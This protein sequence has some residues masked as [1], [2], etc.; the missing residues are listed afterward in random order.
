LKH[1]LPA[2]VRTFDAPLGAA[3]RA[4]AI[5]RH[6]AIEIASRV[7]AEQKDALSLERATDLPELK[8]L[9]LDLKEDGS[10]LLAFLQ[11]AKARY[12]SLHGPVS[13]VLELDA[14]ARKAL[15]LLR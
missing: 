6:F 7:R 10:H 13:D 8:P 15:G 4:T 3:T 14:F 5:A 11:N 12:E 1:S 9:E 2:Q